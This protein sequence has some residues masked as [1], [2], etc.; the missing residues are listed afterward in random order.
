VGGNIV[1]D[2][3]NFVG[4]VA[5]HAMRAAELGEHFE[6]LPKL[7]EEEALQVAVI[8]RSTCTRASMLPLPSPWRNCN[9]P[10]FR[11]N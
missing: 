2:D 11:K 7:T 1:H 8:T 5:Y 4:H 6:M 10:A 3:N 9:V